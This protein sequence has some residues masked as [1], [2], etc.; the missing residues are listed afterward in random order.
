MI[1]IDP[2]RLPPPDEARRWS[3][4]EFAARLRHDQACPAYN[5]HLRQLIH[6]GYKIAAE[7]GD[8]YTDLLAASRDV[9]AASVT[10]N[11]LDR[12]LRPLFLGC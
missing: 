2:A 11:V 4:A 8:R 6:V 9:I 10:A 5:P 12:H 1:D 3:A 7:M